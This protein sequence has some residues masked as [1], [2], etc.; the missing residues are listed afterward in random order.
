[1]ENSSYR[2][3]LK[4]GAERTLTTVML[5]LRK[6]NAVTRKSKVERQRTSCGKSNTTN[7]VGQSANHDDYKT[8]VG[9]MT[10]MISILI[11]DTRLKSSAFH[12]S[13]SRTG[14]GVT[15]VK[16]VSQGNNDTAKFDQKSR[17]HR[18]HKI[19]DELT[20]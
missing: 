3:V 6:S 1:M 14:L 17:P 15:R 4:H 18:Y 8:V 10:A 20:D 2:A 7:V 12:T 11:F 9:G 13:L 5:E 19:Y 16:T